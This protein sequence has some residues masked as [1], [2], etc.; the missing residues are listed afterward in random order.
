MMRLTINRALIFA[1]TCS[2]AV[3][4]CFVLF[5]GGLITDAASP[6]IDRQGGKQASEVKQTAGTLVADI[7][8]TKDKSEHLKPVETER[9]VVTASTVNKVESESEAEP[10][11]SHLLDPPVLNAQMQTPIQHAEENPILD[12]SQDAIERLTKV[13][14]TPRTTIQDNLASSDLS[15]VGAVVVNAPDAPVNKIQ[16]TNPPTSDQSPP[17]EITQPVI[18]PVSV[19]KTASHSQTPEL[20]EIQQSMEKFVRTTVTLNEILKQETITVPNLGN[21]K[22]T[23]ISDASTGEDR[24]PRIANN[25][26]PKYPSLLLAKGIGG[27]VRLRVLVNRSGMVE[28]LSVDQSSGYKAFDESAVR[29]VQVWK[30]HP[31]KREGEAVS[32]EVIVPIRFKAV[33]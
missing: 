19:T 25:Q 4:G 2:V 7:S 17:L 6:S 3:H 30:F 10:P 5:S 11:Q 16:N 12:S 20:L 29:A 27:V 9:P 23:A 18:E 32:M 24:F 22:E 31:A 13:E 28:Q 26:D 14:F 8:E 21:A 33:K 1:A 15:P